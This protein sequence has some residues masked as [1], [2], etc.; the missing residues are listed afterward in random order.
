MYKRNVLIHV[1][2]KVLLLQRGTM[3]TA[4]LMKEN[5]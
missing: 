5:I 3:I 2:A 1:L 4:M